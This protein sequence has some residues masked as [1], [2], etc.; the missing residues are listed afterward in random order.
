MLM[1]QEHNRYNE[2]VILSKE[3]E[4][5]GNLYPRMCFAGCRHRT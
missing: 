4:M 1:E 3:V 2:I 5:E